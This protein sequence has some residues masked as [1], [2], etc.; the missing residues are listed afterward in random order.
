MEVI[1]TIK[2]ER[3]PSTKRGVTP[4]ATHILNGHNNNK[5]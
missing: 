1:S 4:T 5:P 2:G 3:V